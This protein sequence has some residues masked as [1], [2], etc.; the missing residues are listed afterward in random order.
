MSDLAARLGTWSAAPGP[1]HRK[2]ADALEVAIE[3]GDVPAGSLLPA[4]R[5]MARNLAVS[6]STVVAAYDRLRSEGWV[7]SRQGSG[8]RVRW[9]TPGQGGGGTGAATRPAERRFVPDGSGGL[10]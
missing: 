9:A 2:L 3:R 8:T 1:L 7:E 10:I 6:R 5:V 4:E